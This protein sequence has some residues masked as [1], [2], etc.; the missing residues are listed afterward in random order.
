MKSV[1]LVGFSTNLRRQLR[2]ITPVA[3]CAALKNNDFF[4]LA[5]PVH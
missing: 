4:E 1:R 5:R 3:V 2:R